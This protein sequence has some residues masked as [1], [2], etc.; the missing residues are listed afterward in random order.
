MFA[1]LRQQGLTH[2]THLRRAYE[3][4]TATQKWAWKT[5]AGNIGVFDM[6]DTLNPTTE[7]LTA[8]FVAI[9]LTD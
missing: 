1:K 7:E 6:V 9:K 5:K 8:M 3:I 2:V 4:E